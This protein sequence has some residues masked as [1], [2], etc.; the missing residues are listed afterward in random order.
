MSNH[1]LFAYGTLM[2][3]A[4]A[5]AVTGER[6][7]SGRARL[8]HHARHA[9]RECAYPAA[10]PRRGQHIDGLLLEGVTS[11]ALARIDEFEGNRYRRRRV[12]VVDEDGV[13]RSA[14]VYLLRPRW[15]AL[16]RG[17]D[18]CP[19]TFRRE[20]HDHYVERLSGK[21]GAGRSAERV[22]AGGRR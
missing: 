10:V 21:Y 19:E 14:L 7:G 9:L 17:E 6:I 15:H 3:P 22:E 11:S 18:W 5:T 4:I 12:T 13:S 8:D 20:W 1:D 16:L 2:F